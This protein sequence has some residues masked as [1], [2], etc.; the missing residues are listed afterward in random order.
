MNPSIPLKTK[1]I[2]DIKILWLTPYGKDKLWDPALRLRRINVHEQFQKFGINSNFIFNCLDYNDEYLLKEIKNSN[3]VVFTE[4]S[5]RDLFLTKEARKLNIPTMRDHCEYMFTGDLQ[6][7]CFRETDLVVCSSTYIAQKSSERGYKV[8]VIP[9]MW[10]PTPLCKIKNTAGNLQAVYMGSPG[11]LTK[12]L[13]RE[14]YSRAIKEAGYE[15]NVITS[16]EGIKNNKDILW[17]LNTWPQYYSQFD[18]ALCP[19]DIWSFPGK[20]NVRVAQ[21]LAAGYPIIASPIQSY[22]ES[23]NNCGLLAYSPDDWKEALIK[24]KNPL[25]RI[26]LHKRALLKSKEY[27]PQNISKMWLT[28][29]QAAIEEKQL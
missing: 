19:Q 22:K 29:M 26:E 4:Q 15:L 27:S 21:A 9:D 12:M 25:L 28:K 1:N 20:S 5:E 18:V 17:N 24:L 16:L 23:L 13:Y 2:L 11:L 3:L 10:E 6:D 7:D 14:D 8:C